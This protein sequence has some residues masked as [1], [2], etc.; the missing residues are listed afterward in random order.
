VR[1]TEPRGDAL[2]GSYHLVTV[3]GET[4]PYVTDAGL[5]G[6][7]RDLVSG[8]IEFQSQGRLFAVTNYLTVGGALDGYEDADT[9][10]LAYSVAGSFLLI[11][12]PQG[13][14][15]RVD[16]ASITDGALSLRQEFKLATGIPVRRAAVYVK[17]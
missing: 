16:T 2:A 4:L 8:T 3:E 6:A 7:H 13:T 1:G 9:S 11:S 15:T 5:N 17:Q 12:R 14:G 10:A